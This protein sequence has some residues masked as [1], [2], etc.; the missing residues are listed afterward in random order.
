MTWH[1][2]HHTAPIS[3]STGLSSDFARAKAAS[4]HSCQSIGWC[5]AERKYGLVESLRR[6]SVPDDTRNSLDAA[7]LY[8]ACTVRYATVR[9]VPLRSERTLGTVCQTGRSSLSEVRGSD[10]AKKSRCYCTTS[11]G[12]RSRGSSGL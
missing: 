12:P 5:A 2:W 8:R 10:R 6:F 1:Q 7:A 9:E 3:S 11:P 4:P